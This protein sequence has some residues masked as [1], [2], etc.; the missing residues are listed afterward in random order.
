MSSVYLDHAATTP[1]D[2]SVLEAMKPYFTEHFAN[3]SSTH[4]PGREANVAVE[5]A[6]KSLADFIGAE[7]SEIVFTSG[8]TESNNAAIRGCLDAAAGSRIIT[9]SIEHHA[10]LNPIEYAGRLG[11]DTVFLSPD[12]QGHIHPDQVEEQIDGQTA[13]V[14]L[15]L[16]N[17]ELGSINP[18]PEIAEVCHRYDVPLHV[19]AV[20]AI[21]KIPVE[22]SELGADFLSI[23]A[24]KI[25]GPKGAGALYING[26]SSWNAWMLGG[27]QER[28][29]RGGTLNVPGI[30]GLGKA[31]ERA[32]EKMEDERAHFVNLRNQLLDKLIH[33]LGDRISLN[34]SR[35]NGVPHIMNMTLRSEDGSTYDGEML[36]LNL[37][38]KGIYASS[39]SA[40][41]SGAIEPSH[42]LMG[43][44]LSEAEA[45][46][47]LRISMGKDNSPEDITYFADSLY[48]T[49]EQMGSTVS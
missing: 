40:C 28:K 11:Y 20:Q 5:E 48:E 17:N 8:G 44:G 35:D 43:L 29:R 37:D 32:S 39:G 9:S 10:V 49:L 6:R 2:P 7:S 34:G 27:S 30:I 23:S 22:V 47:S 46:S 18:I 15:M 26:D 38:I 3:A 42:V 41:T 14:S 1:V 25:Y 24:H 16:V 19:D 4:Q 45:E 33:K 36:L 31:I 12:K 21:G 13:L